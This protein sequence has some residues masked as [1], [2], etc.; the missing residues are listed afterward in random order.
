MGDFQ[1]GWRKSKEASG[2]MGPQA[3]VCA[4]CRYGVQKNTFILC[5]DPK[6]TNY[7]ENSSWASE[8]LGTPSHD[9]YKKLF[10]KRLP[11]NTAH[12]THTD[13]K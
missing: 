7:C 11:P 5:W 1:E 2:D 13:Q 10:V 4:T 12:M 3:L 6:L 8:N 9:K